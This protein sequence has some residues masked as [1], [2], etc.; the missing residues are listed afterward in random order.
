[1]PTATGGRGGWAAA[2][3]TAVCWFLFHSSFHQFVCFV[4]FRP[5]GKHFY[6]R[7]GRCLDAG[8]RGQ[9]ETVLEIGDCD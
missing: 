2:S 6:A 1:M 3:E 4:L 8:E 9:G 5:P 7:G